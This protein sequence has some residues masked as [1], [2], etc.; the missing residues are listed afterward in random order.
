MIIIDTPYHVTFTSYAGLPLAS[1][2]GKCKK[3]WFKEELENKENI[4]PMCASLMQEA[5]EGVHYKIID[6][7]NR[8]LKLSDFKKFQELNTQEKSMLKEAFKNKAK[9]ACLSM[10]KPKF[11]EKAK[12]EWC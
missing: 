8:E 12:A 7:S 10:V 4:C 9:I 3:S 1:C 6:K 5:V 2:T 11:I